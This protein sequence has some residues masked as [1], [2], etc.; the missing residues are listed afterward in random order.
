M[1]DSNRNSTERTASARRMRAASRWMMVVLGMVSVTWTVAA[2]AAYDL[3]WNVIA[4]GGATFGTG[5]AYSLG[6]TIGQEAAGTSSGGSY[7]LNGGFWQSNTAASLLL[8]SVRS[9]KTHG[10]AGTFDL[11]L[12]VILPSSTAVPATPAAP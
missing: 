1:D 6:A 9:R 12:T 10:L 7:N 2:A 4:S 11:P 5:G 8:Q 3:S